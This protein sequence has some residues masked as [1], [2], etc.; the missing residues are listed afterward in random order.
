M[1]YSPQQDLQ[2]PRLNS[3]FALGCWRHDPRAQALLLGAQAGGL[4]QIRNMFMRRSDSTDY[5]SRPGLAAGRKIGM[6]KPQ[7]KSI[8]DSLS[9]EDFGVISVK[10]A[11]AA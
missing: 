3:R 6:L 9:K 8:P 7:F 2:H 5:G 11:A 10:T 4:A 1:I